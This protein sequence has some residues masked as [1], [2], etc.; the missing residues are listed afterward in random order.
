MTGSIQRRVTSTA[1]T[2]SAEVT[3]GIRTA[4]LVG[5]VDELISEKRIRTALV[6]V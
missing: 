4:T 2:I 3:Y 5:Y 6:C 1:D